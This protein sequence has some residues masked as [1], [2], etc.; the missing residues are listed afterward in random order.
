MQNKQNWWKFWK[1]LYAKHTW[2]CTAL[3]IAGPM[4]S[5][6]SLPLRRLTMTSIYTKKLQTKSLWS[7][8]QS[9]HKYSFQTSWLLENKASIAA[10]QVE[11][12]SESWL[13][14]FPEI[15]RWFKDLNRENSSRNG[16]NCCSSNE[17]T[18]SFLA[19]QSSCKCP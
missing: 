7:S 16:S 5:R 19:Y 12:T 9:N 6:T 4:R 10:H 11:K 18:L 3:S 13:I 8:T 14:G 1:L 15:E 2:L 17:T